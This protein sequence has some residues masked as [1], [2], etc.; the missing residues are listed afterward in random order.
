MNL[1]HYKSSD[2]GILICKQSFDQQ[3]TR[4]ILRDIISHETLSEYITSLLIP[5]VDTD[6]GVNS[7]CTYDDLSYLLTGYIKLA[8]GNTQFT[9]E[10]RLVNSQLDLNFGTDGRYAVT[11]YIRSKAYSSALDSEGNIFA[12]GMVEDSDSIGA[13]AYLTKLSIN[14]ELDVNFGQQGAYAYDSLGIDYIAKDVI[15][16]SDDIVL[17]GCVEYN[18]GV[19]NSKIICLDAHTGLP[20]ANFGQA[21]IMEFGPNKEFIRFNRFS[22]GDLLIVF[23]TKTLYNH[24]L[25]LVKMKVNPISGVPEIFRPIAWYYNDGELL[26]NLPDEFLSSTID[27]KISDMQGRVIRQQLVTT[28]DFYNGNYNLILDISNLPNS[29]YVL[30]AFS[31]NKINSTLFVKR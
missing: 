9:L 8:V 7:I 14:G 16:V 2:N 5:S 26:L 12:C 18:A 24:Q 13:I 19:I 6:N 3:V 30:T 10:E 4:V 15:A 22:N 25:E 23:K 20:I 29:M 17:L 1:I 28:K 11:N 27:I 21:G 31:S